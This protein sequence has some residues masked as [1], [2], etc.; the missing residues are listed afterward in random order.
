MS[1]EEPSESP[2]G[3][4]LAAGQQE[5]SVLRMRGL[6][7]AATEDDIRAFFHDFTLEETYLCRRNGAQGG[8]R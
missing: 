4:A 1:N 8:A 2:S 7:F 3:L 5:R 6:P